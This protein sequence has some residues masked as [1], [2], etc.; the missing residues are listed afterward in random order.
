VDPRFDVKRALKL[1]KPEAAAGREFERF[2]AEA[3][4][5]ARL[6][7]PNVV[8]IYDFG[9]DEKTNCFF[10]TM[11]LIQGGALSQ[12]GTVSYERV[13]EI[14]LDALAGLTEIHNAGIIHRDIK[15]GNILVSEQGRSYIADLGIARDDGSDPDETRVG[16]ELTRTGMMIGTVLYSSPEQVRGLPVGKTGDVFSMGLT[17]YKAL[18]GKSVYGDVEKLDSTSGQEVVMYLGSLVHSG[19]ELALSFPKSIPP[20]RPQGI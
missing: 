15:P 2:A 17:L 5:L 9:R 3:K 8:T 4:V 12:L 11:S 18:T 1:L 16:E 14:V 20:H 13:C 6:E 19:A 7:H 10:Y